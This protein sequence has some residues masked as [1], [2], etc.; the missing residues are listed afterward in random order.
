MFSKHRDAMIV[1]Y[2][3]TVTSVLAG[4]AMFSVLGYLSHQ[5]GVPI[6]QVAKEGVGLAFIAYPSAI[7]TMSFV[8][9]LWAL[10]FFFMLFLLGLDS[11]FA[12]METILTVFYDEIP[13][14]RR[15]K[16]W[17]CAGA[18]FIA[19]LAGIPCV[20]QGGP[21]LVAIMNT[22]GGG[23]AVTIAALAEIVA[24]IWIFGYNRLIEEVLVPMLG[25]KTGRVSLYWSIS[26]RFIAPISL[27]IMFTLTFVPYHRLLPPSKL[28]TGL[29]SI[30][31]EKP[32]WE[33]G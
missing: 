5:M 16:A 10:L 8:P 13:W 33:N 26:W 31:H 24:I 19:F 29:F 25:E 1:S 32:I 7:A 14:M 15:N 6:D 28:L 11:E 12:G 4:F 22:F 17:S 27:F 18:S 3:D 21:D 9:H 23:F 30:E 20:M 2:L